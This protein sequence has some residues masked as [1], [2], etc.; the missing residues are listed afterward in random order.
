M[1][2]RKKNDKNVKVRR[3]KQ[4]LEKGRISQRQPQN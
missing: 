3:N 4:K 2:K 1:E